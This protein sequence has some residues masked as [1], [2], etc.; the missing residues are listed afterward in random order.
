MGCKVWMNFI[1][2]RLTIVYQ[3][4]N[5][6]ALIFLNL[7]AQIKFPPFLNN[8]SLLQYLQGYAMCYIS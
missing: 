5:L 8:K 6:Y 2:C 7:Y 4:Y 3:N 1:I